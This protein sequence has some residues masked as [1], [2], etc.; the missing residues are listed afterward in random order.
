VAT[1]VVAFSYMASIAAL[2]SIVEL[3]LVRPNATA[4]HGIIYLKI[5]FI[6]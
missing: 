3:Q 1:A 6:V 5:F 4:R 2:S